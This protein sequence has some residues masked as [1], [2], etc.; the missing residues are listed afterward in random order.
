MTLRFAGYA[1]LFDRIDRGGDIVRRG[2]F[3]GS[4]G[5]GELPLLWQHRPDQ[6][7]GS[8]RHASEDRRGL[9]VIAALDPDAHDALAG[10]RSGSVTGLSFGYRVRRAQ[11]RAP[12]ELIELDLV[13]V[14]L[15]TL[16][17]MPGAKVHM[18][19]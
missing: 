18:L 7:I 2:A 9:R 15:V 12:R 13:E 17:M 5:T 11:G 19:R 3:A 4:L 8:I 6:R 1:A 10:L 14:S 16:P